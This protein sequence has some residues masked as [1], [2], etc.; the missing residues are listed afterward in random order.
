[1][2]LLF[3]FFHFIASFLFIYLVISGSLQCVPK[4]CHPA[5]F[6]DVPEQILAGGISAI[7][8]GGL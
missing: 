7:Y 1:M 8:H 6:F 3:L 4:T 5:H 2:V